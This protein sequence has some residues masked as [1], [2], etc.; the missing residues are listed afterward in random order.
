MK[1]AI[2]V[3]VVMGAFQS[4]AWAAGF[5][6]DVQ[7]G[8]ATGMA[9]AVTAL[10]DDAEAAYCNPAGLAQ[11]PVLDVRVGATPIIPSFTFQN[12]AGQSSSG[13]VRPVPPP[14]LYLSYG[15]TNDLSVGLGVFSP[16][17]LVV[18]WHSDWEGRFLSIN[19]DLKTYYI[20]PE[21]AYRIGNRVRLG[22]G[23]QIVRATVSLR[24]A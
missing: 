9:T 13:I 14:H 5:A 6:I 23:V 19:S 11:G 10:I 21:V 1:T 16:Y 3:W 15:V 4:A 18:P 24:R 7:G 12:S 8:R 20:N 17:G 2:L 22:A